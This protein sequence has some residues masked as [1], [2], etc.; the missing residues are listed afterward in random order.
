MLSTISVTEYLHVMY[1]VMNSKD[2]NEGFTDN[3][4]KIAEEELVGVYSI[5]V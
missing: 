4:R 3:L 5:L 1:E 2:M